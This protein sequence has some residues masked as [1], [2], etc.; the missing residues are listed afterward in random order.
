MYAKRTKFRKF[1]LFLPTLLVYF[2]IYAVVS[3]FTNQYFLYP[4]FST[5]K[6]LIGLV[7]YFFAIMVVIT[8][9][10]S[11]TTN[12]GDVDPAKAPKLSSEE[13]E[14]YESGK[15][16]YEFFQLYCRKCRMPRPERAH[17]C[18]SCNKCVLKMDHH[19]PWVSNCVGLRNQKFFYLFLIT[20]VIGDLIAAL[21]LGVELFNVE[22]KRNPE[23]EN[24]RYL[25]E[26]FTSYS[27]LSFLIPYPSVL[28]F[29]SVFCHIRRPI[30]IIYGGVL[31]LAMVLAIGILLGYQTI[32]ITKN[33]TSIEDS[34]MKKGQNTPYYY[35]HWYNN[36][37][38][39]LGFSSAWKWFLP[40]PES[41]SHNDGYNYSKPNLE[42]FNE[43][44]EKYKAEME[45]KEANNQQQECKHVHWCC[46]K[47]N[48]NQ[49]TSKV[50]LPDLSQEPKL[51]TDKK[52]D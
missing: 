47:H 8:H 23:C 9:T 10:L 37:R 16:K 14:E 29:L 18:S 40:I 34:K 44:E 5:N 7:F 27:F 1:L 13:I 31:A 36:M 48:H 46:C 42:K 45:L 4:P 19:C 28:T 21:C 38:V 2:I 52:N 26:F 35:K 51:N 39:V 30:Y 20:A 11:M 33:K 49:S 41:N 24:G 3:A 12:P 6:T 22:I 15:R 43:I 25:M 50:K 17:H 32:L